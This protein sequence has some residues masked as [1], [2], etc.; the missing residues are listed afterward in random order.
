MVSAGEMSRTAI[1]VS[2]HEVSTHQDRSKPKV[3]VIGAGSVS[4]RSGCR[5]AVV[6]EFGGVPKLPGLRDGDDGEPPRLDWRGVYVAAVRTAG[7]LCV[8][9]L[10][11]RIRQCRGC[12]GGQPR[13]AVPPGY[14]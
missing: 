10:L 8:A 7:A 2:T 4:E 13:A 6:E 9:A 11:G 1:K 12:P 14:R 3:L 5:K